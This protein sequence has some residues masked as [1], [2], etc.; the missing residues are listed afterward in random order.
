MLKWASQGLVKEL[1]EGSEACSSSFLIPK[2]VMPTAP[3]TIISAPPQASVSEAKASWKMK[4]P[5]TKLTITMREVQIPC[6]TANPA[7]IYQPR[8]LRRDMPWGGSSPLK[9]NGDRAPQLAMLITAATPAGT[10]KA[11]LTNPHGVKC[12]GLHSS[13]SHEVTKHLPADERRGGQQRG[14]RGGACGA[15]GHAWQL[16]TM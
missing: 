2:S 4:A 11:A 13:T 5:Q 9:G 15:W 12:I 7:D 3:S 16:A 8:R 10:Q 1:R 14:H 6:P